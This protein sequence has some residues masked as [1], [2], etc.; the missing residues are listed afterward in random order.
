MTVG[1]PSPITVVS[2]VDLEVVDEEAT[3]TLRKEVEEHSP[4]VYRLDSSWTKDAY[5]KLSRLF[6]ILRGLM[7]KGDLTSDRLKTILES[8]LGVRLTDEKLSKLMESK[9]SFDVETAISEGLKKIASYYIVDTPV[10]GN[11]CYL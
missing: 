11:F 2:P 1:K 5:E 6:F 8:D 10:S 7:A 4:K 9:F 3:E